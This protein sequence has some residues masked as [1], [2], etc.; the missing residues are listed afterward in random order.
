MIVGEIR[1]DVK[2]SKIIK[3]M[4]EKLWELCVG[5]KKVFDQIDDLMFRNIVHQSHGIDQ[6]IL[7]SDQEINQSI[8]VCF[9][10]FTDCVNPLV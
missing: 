3:A 7:S 4:F 2:I 8:V 1:I 5:R 6:Q 9:V 10:C